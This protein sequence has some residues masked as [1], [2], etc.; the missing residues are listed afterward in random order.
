LA[1][2]E[3][4]ALAPSTIR[5]RGEGVEDGIGAPGTSM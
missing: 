1:S 5:Q 4:V 2:G 3:E